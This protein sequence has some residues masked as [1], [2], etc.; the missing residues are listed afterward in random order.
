M[1]TGSLPRHGLV[2]SVL[3][4]AAGQAVAQGMPVATPQEIVAGTESC[5][6]AT[7]ATGVDEHRLEADGW[8]HATMSDANGK[9]VDTLSFYSKG[10]LLLTLTKG[11][12]KICIF[13]ARIQNAETFDDIAVAMEKG[14]GVPGK[15]QQQEAHTVY[16]FP[17]HHVVQLQLTGKPGAPSVRVGVG[18]NSE[19][20]K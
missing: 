13:T 2:A 16:W 3:L 17:L 9:P 8:R 5:A 10:G 7:S 18:Y 14:L 11:S 12:A 6:A 4:L 15:G 1:K 20:A 19:E